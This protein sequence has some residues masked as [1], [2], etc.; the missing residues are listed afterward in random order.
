MSMNL[1][2]ILKLGELDLHGDHAHG[3]LSP[4]LDLHGDHGEIKLMEIVQHQIT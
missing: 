4:Q 1:L 2:E 3:G